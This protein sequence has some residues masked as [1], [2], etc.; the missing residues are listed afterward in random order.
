MLPGLGMMSE[1]L[2]KWPFFRILSFSFLLVQRCLWRGQFSGPIRKLDFI[3]L[4]TVQLIDDAF[5][6]QIVALNSAVGFYFE[7]SPSTE[8]LTLL[9]A[10]RQWLPRSQLFQKNN[11]ANRR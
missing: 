9:T 8:V 6:C 1:E 11:N 10:I 2:R 4:P 7:I 5:A 3:P